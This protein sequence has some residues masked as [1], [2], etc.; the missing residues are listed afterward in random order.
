[1]VESELIVLFT[2][3]IRAIAMPLY[4]MQPNQGKN[5]PDLQPELKKLQEKYPDRDRQPHEA[6]RGK[7]ALYKEYGVNPYATMLPLVVQLP[8]L[9]ALGIKPLTRVAFLKNRYIF[10]GI[11]LSKPDPYF[12][13]PVLAALFTFLSSC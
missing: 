8:I 13:L 12:I 3:I 6:D 11:E 7:P 9:M 10:Y 1:M 5:A 2:I 4:N